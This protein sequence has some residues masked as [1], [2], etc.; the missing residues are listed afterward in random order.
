MPARALFGGPMKK[1]PAFQLAA[2]G[3]GGT[4]TLCAATQCT[5]RDELAI[6]K[7]LEMIKAELEDFAKE[8]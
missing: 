3:L 2:I 8:A 7:L 5:D 4:V 6:R 1:K